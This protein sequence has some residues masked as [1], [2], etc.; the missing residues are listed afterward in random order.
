MTEKLQIYV[1]HMYIFQN[2]KYMTLDRMYQKIHSK[3][4]NHRE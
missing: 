3:Q 4:Y 2:Q 1:M